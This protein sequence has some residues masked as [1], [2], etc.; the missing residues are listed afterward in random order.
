MRL[1]D[2]RE[3]V[4][5]F[6][7]WDMNTL[8]ESQMMASDKSVQ[9]LNPDAILNTPIDDLVSHIVAEHDLEV[10]ILLRDEAHMEEPRETYAS[11][12]R[13]LA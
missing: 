10:P 9:A 11:D 4:T 5:Y 6:A 12:E 3:A 1:D 2:I 7:K 8:L 13:R